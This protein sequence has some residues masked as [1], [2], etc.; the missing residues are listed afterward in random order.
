MSQVLIQLPS[1]VIGRV[2]KTSN[3]INASLATALSI[4]TTQPSN[5]NALIRNA[6]VITAYASPVYVKLTKFG[7]A[8]AVACSATD[9]DYVV[10]AGQSLSFSITRGIDLYIYS[11]GDY[12]AVELG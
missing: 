3:P 6:V 10:A 8:P 4:S 9:Y 11:A 7:T 5:V 1:T 2:A 12:S